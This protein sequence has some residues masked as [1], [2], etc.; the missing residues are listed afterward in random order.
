M[1]R[2]ATANRSWTKEELEKKNADIRKLAAE[3]DYLRR[4][5]KDIEMERDEKI[6]AYR[7]LAK[8]N[9]HYR[10]HLERLK[11][12]N[13]SLTPTESEIRQN[14]ES[15]L[16]KGPHTRYRQSV[17]PHSD[18]SP[19]AS[20]TITPGSIKPI[21]Q[22]TTPFGRGSNVLAA[23]LPIEPVPS[24]SNSSPISRN[25][26]PIPTSKDTQ[27]VPR[28]PGVSP[29]PTSVHTSSVLSGLPEDSVSCVGAGSLA[30]RLGQVSSPG[31]NAR[32]E[33]PLIQS[34]L[35]HRYVEKDMDDLSK[36][37][38][39]AEI[40]SRYNYVE[41]GRRSLSR[42]TSDV[43]M[44]SASE[45]A[46]Q[47]E[48]TAEEGSN[49]QAADDSSDSSSIGTDDDSDD[50]SD[51]DSATSRDASEEARKDTDSGYPPRA[52]SKAPEALQHRDSQQSPISRGNKESF[53]EVPPALHQQKAPAGRSLDSPRFSTDATPTASN[54]GSYRAR[55]S[56]T[57]EVPSGSRTSKQRSPYNPVTPGSRSSTILVSNAQTRS[58]QATSATCPRAVA[59]QRSDRPIHQSEEETDVGLKAAIRESYTR[60]GLDAQRIRFCYEP[61]PLDPTAINLNTNW[62]RRSKLNESVVEKLLQVGIE[63]SAFLPESDNEKATKK[64]TDLI[65]RLCNC[66][67]TPAA[68]SS[69]REIVGALRRERDVTKDE[70]NLIEFELYSTLIVMK[71]QSERE[72]S[73]FP[74]VSTKLKRLSLSSSRK[75]SQC[76]ATISATF[77]EC[78]I[79]C[80]CFL[81]I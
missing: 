28:R 21:P 57:N 46:S 69:L 64:E 73:H 42:R 44:Q 9:A 15:P 31:Q 54:A 16:G 50:D 2:A 65:R 45:P 58:T 22:S 14:T 1:T 23:S 53:Q 25:V 76:S 41:H 74:H 32:H 77:S 17:Q 7:D 60:F 10:S 51:E 38:P 29:V 5:N 13:V 3:N 59:G 6:R 67:P 68:C 24:D 78:T 43:S 33:D 80:T 70:L 40:S 62:K 81:H 75:R 30:L 47:N 71:S 27:P 66:N 48:V 36:G 52:G 35:S 8:Q 72:V 37:K 49:E 4:V 55:S 39:L 56:S 18:V 12:D 19:A 11:A 20:P 79:V 61:Q 34:P 63:M 26:S